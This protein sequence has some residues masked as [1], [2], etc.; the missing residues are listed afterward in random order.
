MAAPLLRIATMVMASPLFFLASCSTGAWFIGEGLSHLQARKDPTRYTQAVVTRSDGELSYLGSLEEVERI[1]SL[2]REYESFLSRADIESGETVYPYSFLLPLNNGTIEIDE[3]THVRFDAETLSPGKQK[4]TVI[5]VGD[6][7]TKE[8]KYYA[9]RSEYSL[10][11]S[12]IFGVG[13]VMGALPYAF[14]LSLL[15]YAVG[16]ALKR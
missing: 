13:H 15:I 5:N 4:I 3:F 7:Y 12:R 14:V 10:I 9:T 16:L 1:G 6:D 8:S 11:S 2:L